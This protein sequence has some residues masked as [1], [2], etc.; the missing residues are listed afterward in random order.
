EPKGLAGAVALVHGV[1]P[2]RAT[3]PSRWSDVPAK[4]YV[5][6]ERVKAMDEDGVDAHTFFGNISG[7]AGNTFSNAAFDPEFRLEAIR[8]F[9]DY[10]IEEYAEP[11]PGRFI[12]LAIAPL[13]DVNV[14]VGEVERMRKRGVKGISFAF[15]QQF[16]YPHIADPYW[17]PLWAMAQETGLS[18]NLHIGSGGSQGVGGASITYSGH[19]TMFALAEGSTRGI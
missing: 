4:A 7:V 18:I 1:M 15:P 9:N 10:Q 12:T 2:D 8:A 17:D 19:S 13:W 5:A 14:A 6:A 16:G 3:P 11:F